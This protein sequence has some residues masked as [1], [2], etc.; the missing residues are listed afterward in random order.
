MFSVGWKSPDTRNTLA[1]VNV[2]FFAIGPP[3]VMSKIGTC[4]P[5]ADRYAEP[6]EPVRRL[7]ELG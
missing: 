5:P 2:L 1:I 6:P 3:C 7:P 4:H